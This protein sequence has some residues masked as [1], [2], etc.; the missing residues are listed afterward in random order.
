MFVCPI[1]TLPD[2]L[3]PY[4]AKR[5]TQLLLRLSQLGRLV[6][7]SRKARQHITKGSGSSSSTKKTA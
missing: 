1:A 3:L 6:R 7:A 4:E 5:A 2:N